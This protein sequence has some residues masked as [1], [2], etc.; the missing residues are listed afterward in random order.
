MSHKKKRN[1]IIGSLCTVLLLMVVGYAAFQS[2]LKIKG[3]SNINSNW[4]I[5]ITNITSNVLHGNPTNAKDPEGIG[6]LTASFET[7]L[8]A[9]GDSIKYTITISNQGNINAKLDKITLSEPDNEYVTF[10]TSGLTEGDSLNAGS[11]S[12]LIVTV[13]FKDVEINKMD[14]S[15]SK[16]IVTLDYSQ[17]DG[18]SGIPT[19][20]RPSA[21]EILVEKVVT[22]GDGLY[23]DTTM[24]GNYIYKGRIP[25][26]YI[27]F[28]NETWRIM[29]VESDGTLKIIRNES[30]KK[31]E[32]DRFGYRDSTS[33]GAGGTYCAN[34]STGCNAWAVSD[35]FTNGTY[36]GTVLKDAYLNTYLNGEYLESINEDSKYIVNHNFNVG[37]PGD[38]NDTEDIAIDVTQE[39]LYKWN[40]KIGLMTITE[41]L[42]TTSNTTCTSLNVA[43]NR[44]NTSVC[45][46]NNWMWPQTDAVWTI[47]P[48]PGTAAGVWIANSRGYAGS[49]LSNSLTP[50][51]LPAL[52]L[53][54]N[55]TLSGSGTSYDP[56]T[57]N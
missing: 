49:Y 51:V 11:T 48:S 5:K 7:N 25:N 15:T 29:S 4:D 19:P 24:P 12:D 42:K 55:I 14:K 38:E 45:S 27:T 56:Y 28:N 43:Y 44:L 26:N 46:N 34:S 10:E 39:A 53:T 20:S 50:R 40:G 47:S 13:T 57:I 23:E 16:L 22:T 54:P 8:V 41:I 18:S 6:T 1:I 35:N 32:F 31:R 3:T 9:P 36:T 21:S 17:A 33:N 37:T 30:I 52:Y 2:V